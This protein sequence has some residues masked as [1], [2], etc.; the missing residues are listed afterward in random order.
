MEIE[1][2]EAGIRVHGSLVCL[3]KPQ[4]ILACGNNLEFVRP[5]LCIQCQA[6]ELHVRNI[7]VNEK[8]FGSAHIFWDNFHHGAHLEHFSHQ[9]ALQKTMLPVFSYGY[10][11]AMTAGG[12]VK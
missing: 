8:N 11:S 10:R 4:R 6:E 9:A 12:G 7:V 1:N 5:F 3:H 2:N